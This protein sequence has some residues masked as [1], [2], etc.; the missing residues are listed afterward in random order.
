MFLTDGSASQHRGLA[1]PF[2][3]ASP[4]GQ[5]HAPRGPVARVALLFVF[6]APV[7]LASKRVGP[8]TLRVLRAKRDV[9]T[10]WG[11]QHA[12]QRISS[13]SDDPLEAGQDVWRASFREEQLDGDIPEVFKQGDDQ[14]ISSF[15]PPTRMIITGGVPCFSFPCF[16]RFRGNC[17]PTTWTPPS[18]FRAS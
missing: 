18:S 5:F 8:A 16:P 4:G 6:T 14:G 3:R 9:S 13:R 12:L 11:S 15:S 2:L 1:L 17:L 10:C 7:L